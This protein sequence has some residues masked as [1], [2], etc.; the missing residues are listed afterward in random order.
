MALFDAYLAVDWS[1]RSAP[2]PP[3]PSP[4]SVWV[5]EWDGSGARGAG[6][7]T[8]VS[9]LRTR[10]A[11]YQLLRE[12]LLDH[13]AQGRRVL[14]GFDFPLGYPRGFA[15]ALGLGDMPAPGLGDTADGP[16]AAPWR[17]LW[18]E[19]GRLIEDGPDNANNRFDVAAAL[20][21]RCG[22]GPRAGD[23]G[24]LWGCPPAVA[25]P[26]L[27]STSPR[28]PYG[29]GPVTLARLRW[30][31]RRLPGTQP[32]WKLMGAGSA[33]SQCL[34]GIPVAGRLR[35]DPRLRDAS[36]IWPFETGFTRSP[37]PDDGS[38]VLH[39]EIWPGVLR[40]EGFR[41]GPAIDGRAHGPVIKDEAQ[42]RAVVGWLRAADGDGRLP[43]LFGTPPR[44][45]PGA[46]RDVLAEEG[47]ILGG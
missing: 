34:L 14:A 2:S 1:A 19:L 37:G 45:D 26:W 25:G 8:R 36:R 31:E 43:E 24:P 46:V 32:A 38:F 9:Y 11:C 7:G 4:D 27:R 5:A 33:G 39:A 21:R 13:V 12:R 42:V 29:A 30:A 3:R 41:R 28:Y 15:A 6:D 35:S 17:L 23:P 10:H 20:N 47:W 40:G 18:D 22:T 44:L 16:P